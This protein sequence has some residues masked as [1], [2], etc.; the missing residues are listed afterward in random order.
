MCSIHRYRV[1]PESDM[2]QDNK[3]NRRTPRRSERLIHKMLSGVRLR[4]EAG[5]GSVSGQETARPSMSSGGI[6]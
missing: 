6:T 2:I 5:T 4:P 1:D 3:S